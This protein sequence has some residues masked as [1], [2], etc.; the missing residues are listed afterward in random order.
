M[1]LM[2]QLM[3]EILA[4]KMHSHLEKENLLPT[5]EKGCLK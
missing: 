4:E 3:T 2:W 5:E 1:T